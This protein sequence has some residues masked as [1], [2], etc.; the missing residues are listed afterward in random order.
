MVVRSGWS[1]LGEGLCDVKLDLLFVAV[2]YDGPP[3]FC[4]VSF[5]NIT[6]CMF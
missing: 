3:I 2:V 4:S 5:V 1:M 6:H